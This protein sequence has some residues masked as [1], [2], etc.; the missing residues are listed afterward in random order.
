MRRP[1]ALG[2]I[3]V[4]AALA[5]GSGSAAP[6]AACKPTASSPGPF[7]TSGAAL[8]KRSKI[9]S[10]HVL[11]GRVLRYPDCRPVRGAT[12]AFWQRG[13]SGYT[14]RGRGSVVTNRNGAFRIEGPVPTSYSSR[15]PHIHL[16]IRA[17]GYQEVVTTYFVRRGSK[18]GR[19]TIVLVSEL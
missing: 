8:P 13:P 11:T 3:A 14:Q 2:V 18:G 15:G 4:T 7:N 10:G 12:V 16:D 6:R 5:A 17:A 1:L 9:G 19:I